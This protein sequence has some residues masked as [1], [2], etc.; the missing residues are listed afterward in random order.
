MPTAEG[1]RLLAARKLNTAGN[2]ASMCIT[3]LPAATQLDHSLPAADAFLK[4]PQNIL[5]HADAT[6]R[7]TDYGPLFSQLKGQ[8]GNDLDT[9]YLLCLLLIC[10]RAKGSNSDWAP[11][12]GFLPTSYGKL[13]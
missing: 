8:A 4:V 7:D 11:Y 2:H 5:L 6:Q 13:S 1:R 3:A 9:R 12:I 10:E